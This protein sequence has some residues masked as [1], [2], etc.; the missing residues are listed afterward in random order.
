MKSKVE[1]RPQEVTDVKNVA[2]LLS[3]PASSEKSYPKRNAM[4]PITRNAVGMG[5]PKFFG[6]QI[7]VSVVGQE[8]NICQVE[9]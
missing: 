5:M 3:T 8:F 4:R 7:F 1:C 6:T 2:H 9:F